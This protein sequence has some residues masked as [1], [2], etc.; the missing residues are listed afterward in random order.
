MGFRLAAPITD[1][2][3]MCDDETVFAFV[4]MF[5]VPQPVASVPAVHNTPK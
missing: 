4:A 5:V 3:D 1:W 2:S